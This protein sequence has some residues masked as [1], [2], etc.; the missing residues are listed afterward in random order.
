[1]GCEETFIS[2]SGISLLVLTRVLPTNAL[3]DFLKSSVGSTSPTLSK[4]GNLSFT[5]PFTT[6]SL[7]GGITT[8]SETVSGNPDIQ[9]TWPLLLK[10]EKVDE[11]LFFSLLNYWANWIQALQK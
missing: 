3:S 6:I 1:L 7:C 8:V 10:T 5:F 9:P 2:R 4:I 11:I